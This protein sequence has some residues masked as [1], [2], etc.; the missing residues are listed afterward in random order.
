MELYGVSTSTSVTE[1]ANN[2][3]LCQSH[4]DTVTVSFTEIRDPN[5]VSQTSVYLMDVFIKSVLKLRSK[6]I[7]QGKNKGENLK[8]RKCT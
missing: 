8:W 4:T 7:V 2:G 6:T 1:L 5:K 3:I